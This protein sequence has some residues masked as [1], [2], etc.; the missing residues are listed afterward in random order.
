MYLPEHF[1]A[2]DDTVLTLLATFGAA[3]LVTVV[4]G[5][6]FVSVL[7]MVFHKDEGSCGVLRGHVARN[8][9]Q[10]QHAGAAVAIIRGVDGY[11]TPSFYASK[12]DH[13]K[14]VPTWSYETLNVHGT[15]RAVEDARWLDQHLRALTDKYEQ[16]EA[17]PWSVD[18][19]PEGYMAQRFAQIVGVELVISRIDGKT[20]LSQNKPAKDAAGVVAGLDRRGDLPLRDATLRA[21]ADRLG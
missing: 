5:A 1:V 3:D 20:K 17:E 15:L 19:T 7:P 14:V 8:N 13:G 21:N 2:D 9:V 4:D 6:P 18:D 16:H 10:W 11:I 12:H